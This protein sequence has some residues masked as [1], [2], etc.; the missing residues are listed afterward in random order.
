LALASGPTL[1]LVEFIR[2]GIEIDKDHLDRINYYIISIRNSLDKETGGTI[3]NLEN[4][5]L[6]ADS[7]KDNELIHIRIKQLEDDGILVM[8]WNT[9]IEE[10]L[11]QWE[12]YLDLLK[13]RNPD[14]KRLQSL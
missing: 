12:D 14:D 10:A 9:L 7:E 8:T 13:L 6:I 2:P 5:Y 1:L 4:A 11:K 3:K